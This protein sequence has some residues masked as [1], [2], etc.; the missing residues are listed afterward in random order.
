MPRALIA[1]VVLLLATP[2]TAAA[3]PAL[4]IEAPTSAPLGKAVSITYRGVAEPAPGGSVQLS[5]YRELDGADCAPNA[6]A[7]GQRL[8]SRRA[9]S[10][11][12]AAGP[13]RVLTKVE[14]GA[15]GTWRICAYLTNVSGWADAPPA[16][17]AT[18][19][20]EIVV[21]Q[22]SGVSGC[23]VPRL[24]GLTI[25]KAK[26]ALKRRRCALGR[27]KR[28]RAAKGRPVGSLVVV[29]QEYKA[30]ERLPRSRWRRGPSAVR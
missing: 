13:F 15:T 26:A 2:A 9:G 7:Q 16:A 28:T 12:I 8:Y 27:V 11:D 14:F 23:T 19:T 3:A 10:F 24:R 22:P 6:Y 25:A 5:G 1:A 20:I 17:F 4:T 18:A 30:G 21:G 29:K